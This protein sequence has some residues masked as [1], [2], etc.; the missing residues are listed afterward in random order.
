MHT[1]TTL[2]RAT[3]DHDL[4]DVTTKLKTKLVFNQKDNLELVDSNLCIAHDHEKK[5][6][7]HKDS[8][9]VENVM[10]CLGTSNLGMVEL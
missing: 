1:T 4:R 9:V 7:D 2:K 3:L 6:K 5:E 10:S 8:D